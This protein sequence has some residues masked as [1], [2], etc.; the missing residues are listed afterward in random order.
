M[1]WQVA[2]DSAAFADSPSH[3]QFLPGWE[4]YKEAMDTLKSSL[5]ND[6]AL[7]LSTAIPELEG[8][9]TTI[10]EENAS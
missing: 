4:P 8:Q 7:D 1:N 10:F 9:L 3:E 6:P 2:L 5:L